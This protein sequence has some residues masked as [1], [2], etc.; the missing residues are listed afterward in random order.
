MITNETLKGVLPFNNHNHPFSLVKPKQIYYHFE[1]C[2][3]NEF[4][5]ERRSAAFYPASQQ[6]N[7][8]RGRRS[9]SAWSHKLYIFFVF[10]PEGKRHDAWMLGESHLLNDLERF[11]FSTGGQPM[12]IYGDPAYPV[13]VHLQS[14]YKGNRLMPAM[15]AFNESMSKVRTSVEWV[16]GDIVRSFKFMDFKNNLKIGLSQIGK[17][18]LVCA[19]I[20]NAI[21]CMYGNQT[22]NYFDLNPPTVHEYFN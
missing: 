9:G 1:F 19:L 20:Q 3:C 18:Y 14:P 5:D 16:F 6:R 22:S 15:E 10:I 13:R 4:F 11:A 7:G 8:R 2:K 21:T 12:C 17:M